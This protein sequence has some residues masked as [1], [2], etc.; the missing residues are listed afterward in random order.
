VISALC[1]SR[2]WYVCVAGSKASLGGTRERP[3]DIQHCTMSWC[4]DTHC[5]LQIT[6]ASVYAFVV[7]LFF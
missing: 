2:A 6:F 7:N 3:D 4:H 5:S 1:I